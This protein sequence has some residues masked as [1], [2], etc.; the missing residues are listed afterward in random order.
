MNSNFDI[1]HIKL[2][3]FIKKYHLFEFYRGLLI[4][5]IFVI[6][7][8]LLLSFSE[9][10]LYFSPNAK[11][12]F[13]YSFLTLSILAFSWFV[14]KPFLHFAGFVNPLDKRKASGI[15]SRHF[16]NIKDHLINALELIDQSMLDA[17]NSLLIASIEQKTEE[18]RPVPFIHAVDV[19]RVK[20]IGYYAFGITF[21]TLAVYYLW[22]DFSSSAHRIINYSVAYEKPAPFTFVVQSDL[23]VQKGSSLTLRVSVEGEVVPQSVFAKTSFGT[24]YL[25]QKGKDLFEYNFVSVNESFS[26]LLQSGEFHSKEYNVVVLPSPGI[27]DLMITAIPPGYTNVPKFV[28]NNNATVSVPEGSLVEWRIQ[29]IS[30]DSL[31]FITRDTLLKVEVNEGQFDIAQKIVRNL[32]YSILLKNRYFVDSTLSNFNIVVDKDQFPKISI[33]EKKDTTGLLKSYFKGIIS[34]DYGFSKLTFTVHRIG[35]DSVYNEYIPVGKDRV[36]D[37][38]YFSFDFSD[39]SQ[40]S[41]FEYYFT[42][43]DN[44]QVNGAKS[45]KS[46]Q[47]FFTLPTEEA[48]AQYEDQVNDD[49]KE[50]IDQSMQKASD[51]Q[52]DI[53]ELKNKLLNENMSDWQRDQMLE[54]IQQKHDD[55]KKLVDDVNKA[56]DEKNK[57]FE[58]VS[59]KE[60]LKEKQKELQDLLSKVMDKELEDLMKELDKLKEEFDRNKLFELSEDL[61]MSYEDIEKQL[62]KDIELLKRYDLE[63][64]IGNTIERLDKLADEQQS[65][66]DQMKEMDND[67]V[68][69]EIEKKQEE[70]SELEEEYNKLL[71]ENNSL[72]NKMNLEKFEG[73]F[74]NIN[75]ELDNASEKSQSG[76]KSKSSESMKNAGNQSKSLAE[77]MQ[78][79]MM[80][81]NQQQK[82]ENID[83]LRQILDN[84]II[85]SFDQEMIIEDSRKLKYKDPKVA[86]YANKQQK[87]KENFT[88][89]EDSLYALAKRE[90]MISASI[91]SEVLDVQKNLKSAIHNLE[92]NRKSNALQNQRFVMTATNNLALLL[93][94]ILKQM[95]QQMAQQM[96]GKQQCQN[97]GMGKGKPSLSQMKS[98]QQSLKQQLQQM[99]DQ[100][101]SEQMSGKEPGGKNGMSKKLSQML[102]EQE[103]YNQQ[104]QEML[105]E[106][107]FSPDA[108]KQLNEIKK[109]ME[110]N[111]RDIINRNISQSTLYRQD[112]ILTRLLEAEKAERERDQD[113]KRKS[114]SGDQNKKSSPPEEYFSNEMKQNNFQDV[115]EHSSLELQKKYKRI[116]EEYLIQLSSDN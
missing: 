21:F 40:G 22:P 38:F 17:D 45:T 79:M 87:L 37:K 60:N 80:K 69:K 28:A 62:D 88:V 92:N 12:L 27:S 51:I 98:Q 114:K 10:A 30:A 82:M 83:D 4:T 57:L 55:L 41:A 24:F 86:E 31:Y 95:Q 107:S 116:Y 91:S 49:L 104:L 34:D 106:G 29:S 32:N 108:V 101:K 43:F 11:T 63:R 73:E 112:Q 75:K 81:N 36:S 8:L 20:K 113:N 44:D 70:L 72:E 33:T 100:M 14:I 3:E 68:G 23:E 96:E 102:T 61:E 58:N 42:V 59:E 54:S 50:K 94:E 89:I 76:K 48:L 97:P 115:I 7:L 64:K 74:D 71:E 93:S 66:A 35:S 26:F 85:F 47:L 67:V 111:E 16:P 56:N 6:A 19:S 18:L 52:K 103:K 77:K 2:T 9:L 99:I 53:A 109:L 90:P 5:V 84:L 15:I 1:L 39:Y 65:M 110:K 46:D 13:V 25:K 105:Q 78:E